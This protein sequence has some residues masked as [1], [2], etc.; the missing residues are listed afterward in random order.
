MLDKRNENRSF[1]WNK[2]KELRAKSIDIAEAL[3]YYGVE[4]GV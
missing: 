4:G 2:N 3:I 1:G